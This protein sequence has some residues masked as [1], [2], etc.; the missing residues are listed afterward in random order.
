M[1]PARHA[2]L[3]GMGHANARD[4]VGSALTNVILG[5]TVA[6]SLWLTRAADRIYL[7]L[8]TFGAAI[9]CAAWLATP[10]LWRRAR[11]ATRRSLVQHDYKLCTT[12]GYCLEGLAEAGT[13]PE[14]GEEYDL[15]ETRAAWQRSCP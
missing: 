6:C 11:N 12:C 14:C 1:R 7:A 10:W 3:V 13:C 15:E 4:V 9:L 8:I 5:V 2:K